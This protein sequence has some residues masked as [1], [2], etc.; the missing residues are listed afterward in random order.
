LNNYSNTLGVV[1]EF[2]IFKLVHYFW[3]KSRNVCSYN[4]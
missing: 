1:L 3:I 2:L 4:K